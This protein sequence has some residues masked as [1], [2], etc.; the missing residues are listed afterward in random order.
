MKLPL[1]LTLTNWKNQFI[2]TTHISFRKKQLLIP[3]NGC[4]ECFFNTPLEEELT[5]AIPDGIN[6]D[7]E[8]KVLRLHKEIYGLKQ[9]LLAWY[10]HL[11]SWLKKARFKCSLSDPCIFYRTESKPVWIYVHV[12][13]LAIFGPDLTLFKQE[14]QDAFNMK[15]LGKAELLLGLKVNHLAGRFSLSQEHYIDKLAEEYEIKNLAP[16]NTPLKPNIQLSN[17]TE[18]EVRVFKELEINYQSAIRALNY[19]SLNSRPEITF[20]VSH[21][22]QFL[23]NPGITHWSACLQVLRYLYHTKT[24]ELHYA[25]TG[26]GGVIG[27][28]DADWGN[29]VMDRRSTSGYTISLN[30]KLRNSLHYHTQ[31]RKPNESLYLT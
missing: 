7:K 28:A 30:H 5:L 1:R 6:K 31:Q 24:L 15:D 9:A 14:I 17:A 16:S 20:A 10:N 8:K 3:P 12:D 18:D 26:G 21:L 13:E 4:K 27:Y 22:S 2:T 25:N 19:I 11:A 23:E 29:S